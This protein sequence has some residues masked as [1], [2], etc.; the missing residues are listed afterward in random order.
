MQLPVLKKVMRVPEVIRFDAVHFRFPEDDKWVL[1]DLSFSI[2]QGERVVFTGPSGCG[3]ST[4]LYLINRLYPYNCDGIVK[5]TIT[6]FG[7]DSEAY[8]PGEVN[9][10]IATVFQDP[11]AQFCMQ[12]VEE[13]L[14][15][16]LENLNVHR[17][18][19]DDR[20]AEVL[21][22]TKLTAFRHAVIHNLSGGQKQ[23][24]AVACALIM[25]PEVL[26]MDEPISHL[27]PYTAKQFIRWLDRLQRRLSLTIVA[28]EHRLELWDD[29]FE[30]QIPLKKMPT[31]ATI[32]KR[33]SS[34]QNIPSLIVNGLR[35]DTFLHSS[36]FTL[37]R[38]EVAVLAGPNGSG[39]STML[40]A[41]CGIIKTE[42]KV[43]P[44]SV[45]YV[46]QSPE[47]LFLTKTV[48]E[49]IAYGGGEAV[50]ELIE[51]LHLAEVANA[52]PFA[53]SHGQ[54]RRV[55]IASMLCDGREVI[56][57]D[58]PTSG[59]DTAALEELYRLIDG[60][61]VGGTTF[62]IVTHDMEFAYR[63]AD[64]VLL[65]KDGKLTGKY[66]A[67]TVWNDHQLLSEH[68]LLQPIGGSQR[69]VSFA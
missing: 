12:T 47:F 8:K 48:R 17:E 39:K 65:M 13:E 25:K 54:K 40:K 29:F 60:R 7:K 15:F 50:N 10:R 19:M 57:M 55:A 33:K 23:Q 43:Q 38:G 58:E 69:E 26:L 59:Q 5:G 63:I 51:R 37:N 61:A 41:L 28:I 9:H 36:S 53:V 4:L 2:K 34:K 35:T 67:E 44:N 31:A 62:L 32:E 14:S 22:L 16:T 27:D 46:P 24:I 66:N 1:K 52:H 45:G 21:A 30:R 11:D 3:K 6:L 20:I 18:E 42:G 68:H 56:V 64:S 49:E